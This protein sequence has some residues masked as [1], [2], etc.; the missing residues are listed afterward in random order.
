MVTA[1]YSIPII[2][3]VRVA[4]FYDAGNVNAEA[5]D[6]RNVHF[7]DDAGIGLRIN[8]PQIGPLR[9]DYAFPI[10]HPD[11]VGSSGRFQ[12]SVG[13]ERPL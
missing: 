3:R 12:F 4:A 5:Y 8:I 9:L 10:T 2:D 1:E 6:Y 13:Y 7:A 11:Y